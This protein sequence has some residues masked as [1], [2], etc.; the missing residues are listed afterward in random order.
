MHSLDYGLNAAA[1]SCDGKVRYL[2]ITDIDD[3]T[4]EFRQSDVTLPDASDLSNPQEKMRVLWQ[5]DWCHAPW[6]IG[7]SR[8]LHEEN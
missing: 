5:W 7:P 4:R 8:I 3:E 2:R 1:V 6:I